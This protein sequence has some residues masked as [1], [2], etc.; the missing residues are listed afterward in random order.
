MKT[1]PSVFLLAALAAALPLAAQEATLPGKG[2][3]IVD[4]AHPPQPPPVFFTAAAETR[5]RAAAD[6]VHHVSEVRLRVLQGRV[7]RI[8]LEWTGD[9]IVESV[10]GGSVAGWALREVPGESGPQRF[11]EVIFGALPV[12]D[13]FAE[14]PELETALAFTVKARS[15]AEQL[16][17]E[18]NPALLGIGAAAGFSCT[19]RIEGGDGVEAI[20][21]ELAGLG[22]GETSPGSRVYQYQGG[23]SPRIKLRLQRAGAAAA[24]ELTATR[25]TGQV[26]ADDKIARFTFEALAQVNEADAVLPLL[27]GRVALTSLP[28]SDGVTLALQPKDGGVEL[29]FPRVGLVPLRLVFEAPVIEDAAWRRFDF[30]LGGG[31]MVPVGL[32][33]LGDNVEF[34]PEAAMFPRHDAAA[35]AWAAHLPASGAFDLRWRPTRGPASERVFVNSSARVDVAVTAGLVR[36]ATA[37]EL[38]VLQGELAALDLNLDGPG[39]I[40]A[41]EGPNIAGWSVAPGPGESRR[42]A[43]KLGRPL[44]GAGSLTVVSQTPLEPPPAR[45]RALRITPAAGEVRHAGFLRVAGYGAVRVEVAAARGLLQLAP[46]QWPGEAAPARESA[47]QVFVYRFPTADYDFEIAAAQIVPEISVNQVLVYE[48]G[49]TDRIL[50]AELELDIREAPLREWELLVPADHALASLEGADIADSVLGGEAGP[51]LRRLKVLFSKPVQ[52][53]HLVALRLERNDP[54]KPGAWQLAPLEFPGTRAARG[55]IGIAATPGFRLVPGANSGLVETP[56]SYFPARADGLQ[57]AFRIREGAWQAEMAVEALGQNVQADLFH[58]YTLREGVATVS[59]L[60][61]FFTVGAPATE[62][63]FK[64]PEDAGN[65]A[66]DGQGV[67][68]WRREGEVVIVSLDKAS[69]GAATL[70][71]TFEQ[72]L[73]ARGGTLAPGLVEPLGVQGERGFI[74]VASPF[75]IKHE[76]KKAGPGLLRLEA[77]ELPAEWRLLTGAPSLAVFQYN[78]RPLDLEIAVEWFAPA[79]TA[80]QIVDFARLSSVVSWDGQVVTDARWFVK[81]RGRGSL[82]LTLP[83]GARLWETRAGGELVNAR[84]DGGTTLVPL[85]PEAGTVTP[86]EVVL[87]YG[88]PAA[89]GGAVK[90]AAPTAEVP[91][92]MGEWQVSAERGRALVPAGGNALAPPRLLADTGFEWLAR[93]NTWLWFALL[94]L[95]AGAGHWLARAGHPL[96]ALLAGALALAMC[97]GAAIRAGS[98]QPAP[99]AAIRFVSPVVPAG[100]TI[101]VAVQNLA[102]WQTWVSIPGLVLLAAGLVLALAPRLAAKWL[103]AARAVPLGWTIAAC[104]LLFQRGGAVLFFVVVGAALAARLLGRLGAL[105]RPKAPPAAATAALLCLLA[106]PAAPAR[107]EAVLERMAQDWRVADGRLTA[108]VKVAVSARAGEALE[109]LRAPATLVDF[110]GDGLRVIRGGSANQPAYLVV[111]ERDGRLTGELR[112]ELPLG[113]GA[114]RFTLPTAPA[115]VQTIR[116]EFAEPGWE[117]AAEGA[118]RATRRT[119]VA[120][121]GSGT[122]LVLPPAP[123]TILLRPQTRDPAAEE[124]RF[125]AETANLF[126]PAPGVVNGRHKVTIRP[127]QGLVASL[128]LRV[129]AGFTVGDVAG[130]GTDEWRFDPAARLLTIAIAPPKS[131]PFALMVATQMATGQLPYDAALA[132]LAVEGAAGLVGTTAL[133][134]AGDAQPDK[135]TPAAMTPIDAGDFDPAVAAGATLHQVFRHAGGEPGLGVSVLP[136]QPEVK[137]TTNQVLS[138]AEERMVLAADLKAEIT[139]AGIFKLVFPLPAGLELEA[140]SGDA[141]T[142]WTEAKDGE[143][144]LVTLHLAGRTLGE[145]NF[146]LSL[147]GPFP[148]A[149][150][151]WELPRLVVEDAPRQTGLLTVVPE[152]GIRTRALKRLNV[153]QAPAPEGKAA[154]PGALAFRLLQPDWQLT[155]A[156]ERLEP[157]VTAQILQEVL[158]RDGQARTRV[159]LRLKVENAAVKS[160][161]LRLPGLDEED[162]RSVRATGEAVADLLPVAGEPGLWEMRFQRGVLGEVP[163]ELQFQQRHDPAAGTFSLPVVRVEDARQATTFVALRAAGRLE[164][165]APRL[166]RGWQRADWPAVPAALQDPSDR[167]APALCFRAV[168]PEEAL[169]IRLRRQDVADVLKLRIEKARF[170][171]MLS[172]RGDHVTTARLEVRVTEKASLRMTLPAGAELLALTVNGLSAALAGDDQGLLFHILPGPEPDAPVVVEFAYTGRGAKALR[173]ALRAPGFSVPAEDVEWEVVLPDGYRLAGH[174]GGLAL[175]ASGKAGFGSF[176]LDD[177]LGS[178]SVVRDQ[179]VATGVKDLAEGNRLLAEGQ[180]DRAAAFFN[181]AAANSA[182]DANSNEDARVQLRN[183]Q[184]QQAVVALNTRRQKLFL[185]NGSIA[186][187]VVNDQAAEAA[188]NNPLLQGQQA[189][190]PRQFDQLLMGNTLEET[191]VLRR[192]ADRM[193]GQ[194]AAAGAALR[195]LEIT[196]PESGRSHTFARGVQVDGSAPLALDLT[197]VPEQRAGILPAVFALALIALL[198]AALAAA[199]RP[200][201]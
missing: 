5:L 83:E 201:K 160:V 51:G 100:E 178:I 200:T 64:V 30:T 7:E 190:D 111:A 50:R 184:T 94:V 97:A 114:A 189:Y 19:L 49:E 1:Y 53:R 48:L 95:L 33:G 70:L 71:L 183:L 20:P 81:T 177:Y 15:E 148:G 13:P 135:V 75:Q 128:A 82:R 77:S 44:R 60:A 102:V 52:G 173:A 154:R 139:R 11:L 176:G 181:F 157:W 18:L 152:R 115:A 57:H 170:R 131:E 168:E 42:L 106:M 105:R 36:Q 65:L 58:L 123:A 103:P 109:V 46:E 24:V 104:G 91:V 146:T 8:A 85:P 6:G 99:P 185:D 137:I 80:D 164:A 195:S 67:R 56:L 4:P 119:D 198:A 163:V 156:V 29:R 153:S 63:R 108:T 27:R 166:P 31:T 107:A 133:A 144:R 96:L 73:N 39:E 134:F 26:L 150:D 112:Y 34:A 54:A 22:G 149:N 116:V 147:A 23:G 61:N 192:L 165:D 92:V 14:K 151:E 145:Q 113:E 10:A 68:G 161:R 118:V 38:R 187:G 175:R 194:Q 126:L 62:W 182:L 41:V 188:R 122:D 110:T 125:F 171:S 74:Q 93:G 9:S 16:P 142:H 121:T 196:L 159:G 132:P 21:L 87:R 28:E 25:L 72:T 141:L 35:A 69:L 86:V 59:V 101:T 199:P 78:E 162:A 191:G 47:R 124:T 55:F 138:L 169:E 172:A 186:Q 89:G 193:V 12:D 40:L 143:R 98:G 2:L 197:L 120:A 155:L 17:V 43:V 127:A 130:E 136:V 174:D 140:A 129:P 179:K 37:L 84:D 32:A 167:S 88:Q 3:L 45:G 76:I 158:L 180:A 66:I 79:E 90:L 117:A